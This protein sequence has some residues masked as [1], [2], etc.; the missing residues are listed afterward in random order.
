MLLEHVVD[1]RE[2]GNRLAVKSGDYIALSELCAAARA[3]LV[4]LIDIDALR[5]IVVGRGLKVYRGAYDA[6]FDSALDI[7]VFD[8]AVYDFLYG[9][10]GNAESHALVDDARDF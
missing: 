2:V 3:V 4:N 5:N 6:D 7:A 9:R 10:G 1:F 8:E